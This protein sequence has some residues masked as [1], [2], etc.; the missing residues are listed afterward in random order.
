MAYKILFKKSA[1]K[2]LQKLDQNVY[3]KLRAAID[4]L[5]QSPRPP[6]S[7]KL[8]GSTTLWRLRVGVYRVIYDIQDKKLVVLIIK[9]GHRSRIYK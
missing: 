8:V 1:K 5:A 7:K 6:Q 9:V 4:K 2:E 3:V